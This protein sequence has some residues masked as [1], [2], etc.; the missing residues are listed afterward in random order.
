MTASSIFVTGAVIAIFGSLF[1]LLRGMYKVASKVDRANGMLFGDPKDSIPSLNQWQTEA[2]AA[3]KTTAAKVQ[4]V[5][6]AVGEIR[7]HQKQVADAVAEI[8]H[9]VTTNNGGSLKD[10][11]SRTER[12]LAEHL[13]H[14]EER[15]RAFDEWKTRVDNY[16]TRNRDS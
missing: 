13:A 7:D 8:R 14:Y 1:A 2:T 11:A 5:A 16:I 4:E 15:V 12:N 3:Q 9:E 6:V 10:S